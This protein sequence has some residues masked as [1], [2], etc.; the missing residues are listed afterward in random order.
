MKAKRAGL[1]KYSPEQLRERQLRE[2]E[3]GA[4]GDATRLGNERFRLIDKSEH[5]IRAS[6]TKTKYDYLRKEGLEPSELRSLWKGR[7]LDP[8][9]VST[10]FDRV[11]G[12]KYS[13]IAKGDVSQYEK[14]LGTESIAVID[15]KAEVLKRM[16]YKTE[17]MTVGAIETLYEALRMDR[18]LSIDLRLRRAEI[19]REANFKERQREAD[20]MRE[21][22][23][24][25]TKIKP[26]ETKIPNPKEV[27]IDTEA[28]KERA[29]LKPHTEF[30]E[31]ANK[32]IESVSEVEQAITSKR[33][34]KLSQ[35]YGTRERKKF[36]P[37][38]ERI[39]SEMV[40]AIDRSIK[41]ARSTYASSTLYGGD[42]KLVR[43]MEAARDK[44]TRRV[45][46]AE[47]ISQRD[48]AKINATVENGMKLFDKSA[49]AKRI[50]K[51]LD[52]TAKK[53]KEGDRIAERR[54]DPKTDNTVKLAK[55]IFDLDIEKSPQELLELRSIAETGI[56]AI[57]D[58][59]ELYE[60]TQAKSRHEATLKIIENGTSREK[61]LERRKELREVAEERILTETEQL[62]YEI[63]QFADSRNMSTKEIVD[64][65]MALK[66]IVN[67]GRSLKANNEIF[68]RSLADRDVVE[69]M[70]VIA[71]EAFDP[72]TGEVSAA[73]VKEV[74]KSFRRLVIKGRV[75]IESLPTLMDMLMMD[76][77]GRMP[78]TG[79][80]HSISD[81][82]LAARTAKNVEL[83]TWAKEQM[84]AMANIFGDA[85]TGEKKFK[86]WGK[87]KHV[88]E[89]TSKVDVPITEEL[90][91]GE[92]ITLYQ[93]MNQKGLR[94]TF[95]NREHAYEI[96][97]EK[98]KP[99]RSV[100]SLKRQI[101]KYGGKEAIKWSDWMIQEL[102]PKMYHR[103]NE[104][105]RD[106][107]GT[108][109]EYILN[110]SPVFRKYTPEGT[111]DLASMLEVP[112]MEYVT[113]AFASTK[114]RQV[115][116]NTWFDLRNANEIMNAHI[117][118]ASHY[119]HFQ[120]V[121]NRVSRLF[122]D[123][124]FKEVVEKKYT[125]H[126]NDVLSKL[127][128]DITRDTMSGDRWKVLDKIRTN[129][130]K[131]NL[132]FNLVLLPK[133]MMSTTAMRSDVDFTQ[134]GAFTRNMLLPSI[135]IMKELAK[136]SFIKSRYEMG[137][138]NRDIALAEKKMSVTSTGEV[139]DRLK[140][141]KG[142]GLEALDPRSSGQLGSNM[143]L[144]TK[145]GD[146]GAILYGG[147][148]LYRVKY[149]EYIK[150]GRS[151]KDAQQLAFNDFVRAV[152]K[153]Q[154][155][156]NLEDLSHLQRSG[157]WGKLLT[158]FQNTPLQY[159][160]IEL[161]ALSN[162]R[163][164]KK[165]KDWR[166]WSESAKDFIIYHMVLPATFN[167]A[168][169]GFY[170]DDILDPDKG[171][172]AKWKDDPDVLPDFI[173]GSLQY[174]PFIGEGALNLF[175][176]INK[177]RAFDADLGVVSDAIKTSQ[178]FFEEI[179]EALDGDKLTIDDVMDATEWVRLRYGIPAESPYRV[180]QGWNK[181]MSGESHD[182]RGLLGYSSSVLG[183]FDRSA[184]Y[185][186]I[187]K[188]LPAYGGDL[189]G[190]FEEY[191]E[192]NGYIALKKNKSRLTKEY[193]MYDE[194]GAWDKNV[195]FIH[196]N[197]EGNESKARYINNLYKIE[198]SQEPAMRRNITVGD[199]KYGLQ[200][201][202]QPPRMTEAEFEERLGLW[203]AYG[204]I[205]QDVAK[206]FY[207]LKTGGEK[208]FKEVYE[209]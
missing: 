71:P 73:K 29:E 126:A 109:L 105:Y 35:E 168:A 149:A 167:A 162:M 136:T 158:L 62:E 103:V 53:K 39:M 134:Q 21:A 150:N 24:L 83:G 104:K 54:F 201:F 100:Y 74:K 63:L 11:L 6:D 141:I 64:A 164:A 50:V 139:T 86:E 57:K 121:A 36:T 161:A 192:K 148:A 101:I 9:K 97:T 89:I 142:R 91:V 191:A 151:L 111:Q 30:T 4:L 107:K 120:D 69:A 155:S 19:E 178:T 27:T 77:P 137:T 18:K 52:D 144:M 128:D 75:Y 195:N 152:R 22:S 45:I 3:S 186:L 133:Q 140:F 65:E 90:T 145:L 147:Q 202:G 138:F 66:V 12:E 170:I 189:D 204:V 23:M 209:Q 176:L 72:V 199:V 84:K 112:V 205:S 61:A 67:N 180:Y 79:H 153:T 8:H 17:K 102:Y 93:Y 47:P 2:I 125:H 70:K 14:I 154:Q 196:N 207:V 130:V 85:K 60:N 159:L 110:Y 1:F 165:D 203:V 197:L 163:Q 26:F 113:A 42:S 58:A 51:R 16:D 181:F 7:V 31:K 146:V 175:N 76:A 33:Q 174:A 124:R 108:D 208:G 182:V 95:E 87:K 179:V 37:K 184:D 46:D 20:A 116:T 119:I 80:L 166:K 49:V 96:V 194:F 160:R 59:P 10:V 48:L 88:F 28:L 43:Q 190:L 135:K 114:S 40:D 15:K 34:K 25:D 122:G 118:R 143:L 183:D 68:R 156:G 38:V 82:V 177:D 55:A 78:W 99:G 127:T 132:G 187:H 41:I 173:M 193:L 13:D 106:H 185:G 131:A 198:V 169:N 206:M 123:A 200:E 115:N 98:N 94:E 117:E 92:A 81:G 171:K 129:F 44:L 5:E 32:H 188:H 56:Q 157:S 172:D